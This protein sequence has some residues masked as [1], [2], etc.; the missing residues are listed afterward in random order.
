VGVSYIVLHVFQGQ[1]HNNDRGEAAMP[2]STEELRQAVETEP[3]ATPSHADHKRYEWGDAEWMS[4]RGES[5][6]GARPISIYE[7]HLAS[8]RRQRNGAAARYRDIAPILAEHVRDMGFTHVELMPLAEHPF[9]GSRHGAPEDLMYLV[10]TLHRAGIGVILDWEPMRCPDGPHSCVFDC[11]RRKVCTFLLS[12]ARSWLGR[13]HIDALRVDD[14]GKESAETLAFS[15]RLGWLLSHDY[16]DVFIVGP[17]LG[18]VWNTGWMNDTLDYLCLAPTDRKFHHD[19]L[20][21]STSSAF[22]ENFVLPL[23]HDEVACGK[24][25]LLGRMPGDDWQR[26]AG[27]RALFGYMWGHPGKKLLFMGGEFGQRAEWRQEGQLDWPALNDPWHAG[28]RRWVRDLNRIYREQPALHELDFDP[29]G[30]RWVDW[31]GAEESLVAFL[32]LARDGSVVLVV[33]NFTPVVRPNRVIGVPFGGWWREL[34]NSDAD[35]YAG[36]GISNADGIDA[37][38]VSAHG[39]PWSLRLTLPP[40]GVLFLTPAP[41]DEWPAYR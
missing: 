12:S 13:Y 3:A 38:P 25:S 18:M 11:A 23:P 29:A 32:R 31:S 16:P 19:A 22:H 20:R 30:F 28:V 34:L 39:E 6:S 41:E 33:C 17:G 14:G 36:S 40:L 35:I 15:R 27:L 7:L 5:Q 24:G 8:W 4:A 2:E 21:F 26:F 10:D 37:L 9:H 1:K